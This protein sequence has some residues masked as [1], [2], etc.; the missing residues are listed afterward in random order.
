MFKKFIAAVLTLTTIFAGIV[1]VYAYTGW[2]TESG[3]AVYYLNDVKVANQWVL[4]GSTVYFL[5]AD[6]LICPNVA[7]DVAAAPAYGLTYIDGNKQDVKYDIPLKQDSGD[8]YSAAKYAYN[9]SNDFEAYVLLYP[10]RAV[11][12]GADTEG[13]YNNY[14][15]SYLGK[16]PDNSYLQALDNAINGYYYHTHSFGHHFTKNYD[17]TH[18]SY[19]GCGQWKIEKC[20]TDNHN[21]PKYY[22]CTG[23]G[24]TFKHHIEKD[25]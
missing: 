15:S 13:L 18:K 19:C 14:I 10:E 9:V 6:G 22:V 11:A 12:F 5:G 2:S 23:C 8:P 17:G 7:V 25:D 1:P 24:Q 21:S 4:Y 20:N 16:T 3:Q